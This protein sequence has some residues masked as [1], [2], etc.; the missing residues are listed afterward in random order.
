MHHHEQREVAGAILPC[1]VCLEPTAVPGGDPELDQSLENDDLDEER[2]AHKEGVV[3]RPGTHRVLPSRT[4]SA[5]KPGPRAVTTAWSPRAISWARR[6]RSSTNKQVGAD[7][8]PYSRST[9]RACSS[10]SV[11]RPR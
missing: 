4:Y 8:L 10:A 11:G 9:S 7:M 1:S 3:R 5:E 2:E 6:K